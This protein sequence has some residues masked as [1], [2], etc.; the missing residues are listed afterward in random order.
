MFCLKRAFQQPVTEE[1]I[2]LQAPNRLF[3]WPLLDR[4]RKTG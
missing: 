1:M 2:E 4:W 3:N